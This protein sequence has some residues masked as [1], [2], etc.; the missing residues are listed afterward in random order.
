MTITCYVVPFGGKAQMIIYGPPPERKKLMEKAG[1]QRWHPL[2]EKEYDKQYPNYTI[3]TVDG[4]AE[5]F[6]QRQKGDILYVTDDPKV[7][8]GYRK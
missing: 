4:F 6:E 1:K 7:T 3:I 8:A 2:S 5:V